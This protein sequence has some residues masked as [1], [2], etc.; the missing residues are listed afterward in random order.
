M[1]RAYVLAVDDPYRMRGAVDAFTRA[2]ALDSTTSEGW[3]QF[4]QSLMAL[5]ENARAETAYRK[6]FALDPNRPMALMSLSAMYLK[7]GKVAEAKALID[8]AVGASRTVTSP[9]VRVVR[10]RI[11]LMQ[12]DVRAARDEADLALAMDTNYTIPARSL[13][14]TVYWTEGDTVRAAAELARLLKD[15]GA[16]DPSPTS[17]R[18]AASALVAQG[19]NE[20]ALTLIER[21]RPRGAYLWFYLQSLDFQALSAHPRFIRVIREADPRSAGVTGAASS[22]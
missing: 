18:Y 11:A 3:Y 4:G 5:G 20:Q 12:G 21:A 8:S 22:S 7:S 10:G 1:T 17:A 6:A 16:G 19:R 9:Y 2:L 15:L 13:L 14:A